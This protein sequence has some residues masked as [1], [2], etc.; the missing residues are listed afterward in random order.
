MDNQIQRVAISD[1]NRVGTR[2]YYAAY[3]LSQKGGGSIPNARRYTN[4]C[5]L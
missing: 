1:N 3:A 4:P 2:H 5:A